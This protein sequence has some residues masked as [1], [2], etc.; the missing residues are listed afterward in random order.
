MTDDKVFLDTN[1]IIY[2]YDVSAGEKYK[3]GN[4]ESF[5]KAPLFASAYIKRLLAYSL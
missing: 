1:I 5:E 2:A 3:I 4:Y